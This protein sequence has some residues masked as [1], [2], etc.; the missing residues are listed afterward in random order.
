MIPVHRPRTRNILPFDLLHWFPY[1]SD[2]KFIR[3]PSLSPDLLDLSLYQL[4]A[5]NYPVIACDYPAG[6]MYRSF[7]FGIS[8]THNHW[9][10]DAQRSENSPNDKRYL[11][12]AYL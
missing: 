11:A 1:F 4:T 7:A 2:V 3:C 9:I 6:N 5:L 12:D 10:G 8:T